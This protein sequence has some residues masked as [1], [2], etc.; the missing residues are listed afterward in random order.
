MPRTLRSVSVVGQSGGVTVAAMGAIGGSSNEIGSAHRAG[1]VAVMVVYGLLG[2]EVDGLFPRA[3]GC[4]VLLRAET[5]DPTD[6]IKCVT[7]EGR[8]A[9][10]QCKHEI[11]VGAGAIG[12]T[13]VVI[14]WAGAV[15]SGQVRPGDALVLAVARFSGP[16]ELLRST[17]DRRRDP[18]GGGLTRGQ[19]GML[20][21]LAAQVQ[22]VAPDLD[23]AA[24]ARL[25][26]SAVVWQVDA[27]DA[28][29]FFTGRPVL[30]QDA[31]LG[32]ALLGSVVGPDGASRAMAVLA[33]TARNLARRRSGAELESWRRSLTTAG[34]RIV[35]QLAS[36]GG[37][38]HGESGSV[39]I[40]Q[41]PQRN[42]DFTGRVGLIEKTE[43]V[44]AQGP[45]STVAL[46]GMGGVGKT[47][48]AAE[49]AHRGRRAGRYDL[50]GWVRAE[51]VVTLIQDLAALASTLGIPA[52]AGQEQLA[53]A[54]L[55]ELARRDRW[56]LVYDNA[57]AGDAVRD[58]LPAGE[59]HVLITSRSRGWG[60]LARGVA[61][62][63]FATSEA[64]AYL[65]QRTDGTTEQHAELA[66]TL[67]Y[68]PLALA[69]AASYMDRTG[70]SVAGYL[71]LYRDRQGAGQLLASGQP[72]YPGS[73]ATTWL[74]HFEQ[75]QAQAP[76]ALQLLQMCAF[77][78]PDDIDLSL[79]A[80]GLPT[81]QSKL[82]RLLTDAAEAPALWE[83]AVG[84]LVAQGLA[85]RLNDERI[86]LHRLISDVTRYHLQTTEHA[87]TRWAT[88]VLNVLNGLTPEDPSEPQSWPL[89]ARL[90]PHLLTAADH[91]PPI[92]ACGDALL[93]A[94]QYLDRRAEYHPAHQALRKALAVMEHVHG[95][96]SAETARTLGS[97]GIVQHA[98][99]DL[100]S[101]YASQQRALT[102]YQSVAESDDDIARTS[103]NL[104]IV[105][106]EMGELQA[107][108]A[109]FVRAIAIKERI[110]GLDDVGLARTLN[111]FGLLQDQSGDS[112]AALTTF[113][114][115]LA[116]K[117]RALGRDHLEIA[118][119][120]GNLG[121]VQQEMGDLDAAHSSQ[122]QA[123]AIFENSLGSNHPET[124]VCLT[125][126][127]IV[128]DKLGDH[129][130][131]RQSH[132]RAIAIFEATLG[133]AHPEVARAL[134]NLGLAE[135]R[136]GR[137]D[138]ARESFQRALGL[139]RDR[140]GKSHP[141]T[142]YCAKL[143]AELTDAPQ[144]PEQSDA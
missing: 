52:S 58:W 93:N 119:T 112:A 115:A 141:N 19:R 67:G 103:D 34:L 32:A 30:G 94:G 43:Q 69:Q 37:T 56:L 16:L 92:E 75:L 114:R 63:Q 134:V 62:T 20:Q 128:Q 126:L 65:D 35:S 129:D 57:P 86:R 84:A 13:P 39:V 66:Q 64:V 23:E 72:D 21:S 38:A 70:L 144:M 83:A 97:L 2:Q 127:G 80:S 139:F 87:H 15:R 5:D 88:H 28:E 85:T 111:N 47:Q 33:A 17:L 42:P 96:D 40:Y 79:L 3:A 89:M 130:A 107:A 55:R 109:S 44:L 36:P 120:L 71:R 76:A 102:I 46:Y 61:V 6:D 78:H 81:S 77:C 100:S 8:T 143:L 73:V 68:L 122:L 99:D 7:S 133:H 49:I 14:Q 74:I 118:P 106:R 60:G 82:T 18:Y 116:I 41:L 125:N 108:H 10:V 59:G 12:L 136:I 132:L 138:T 54:V 113:R 137:L 1:A 104:G 50:V 95:R 110:Y 45:V 124:A 48:I 91:A 98:L 22:R 121:T 11:T 142:E 27:G 24:Q 90:T 53:A 105:Q 9:W 140:Y 123:L 101:A 135:Q 131:S 4:P 117:E 29:N 31:R 26:D 25:L 51:T